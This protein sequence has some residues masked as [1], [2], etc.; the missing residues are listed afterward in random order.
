MAEIA[1][2]MAM[3]TARLSRRPVRSPIAQK[4]QVDA[5]LML[6]LMVLHVR[7]ARYVRS[8]KAA[9]VAH[10]SVRLRIAVCLMELVSS[11]LVSKVRVLALAY[12]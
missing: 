3:S 12:R 7:M 6:L 2:R 4:T 1:W 8:M 9:P 5:L 10:V 11:E